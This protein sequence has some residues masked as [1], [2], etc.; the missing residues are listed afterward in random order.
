MSKMTPH[1]VFSWEAKEIIDTHQ[2]RGLFYIS[3]YSGYTGI[4]N[5]NGDAWVEEFKTLDDCLNWLNGKEKDGE[6][7]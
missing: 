3:E 5:S 4:D 2:P 7:E 1:E 6:N